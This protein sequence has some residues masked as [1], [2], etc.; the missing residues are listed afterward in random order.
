[1]TFKRIV[2]F[3]FLGLIV[4][5]VAYNLGGFMAQTYDHLSASLPSKDQ[6]TL[7]DQYYADGF[8]SFPVKMLKHLQPGQ[9][10]WTSV[11]AIC[12]DQSRHVWI[13]I[14]TPVFPGEIGD[15]YVTR[16]GG[17][18]VVQV[19]ADKYEASG[20]LY[21]WWPQSLP[22]PHQ[23]CPVDSLTVM[24]REESAKVRALR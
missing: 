5:F 7:P 4:P 9:S 10:A 22:Q 6:A 14:D 16:K 15:L 2:L 1:M 21:R 19:P 3:V 23:Y 12:V 20:F 11:N 24:S 17:S 18:F 13:D 8:P